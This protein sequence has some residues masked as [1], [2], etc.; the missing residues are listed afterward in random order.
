MRRMKDQVELIEKSK[1]EKIEEAVKYKNEGKLSSHMLFFEGFCKLFNPF[2]CILT[3]V[4]LKPTKD[5][6]YKIWEH[7][8]LNPKCGGVCG[9]MNL[10]L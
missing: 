7:L 1:K 3:D 2:Y 9:Y 6:I 10:K 4:G 5:A 8:A